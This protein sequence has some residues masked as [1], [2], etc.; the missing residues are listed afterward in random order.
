MALIVVAVVIEV[1]WLHL[2]A[3]VVPEVLVVVVAAIVLVVVMVTAFVCF[4][5]ARM[6]WSRL[7]VVA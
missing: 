4:T 7:E 3:R 2:L 6:I 5:F 1:P